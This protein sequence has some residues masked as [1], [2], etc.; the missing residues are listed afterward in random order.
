M[1]GQLAGIP[2]GPIDKLTGSDADRFGFGGYY[3]ELSDT[4]TASDDTVWIQ[5]L[6]ASSELPFS[7][8][9]FVDTFNTCDQNLIL[10]NWK[11]T[12]S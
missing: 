3:F 2:I 5:L 9:V 1:G 11:Q 4:P 7:A 8:Q 12:G 10:V 6:D